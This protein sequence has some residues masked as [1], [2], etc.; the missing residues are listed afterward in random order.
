MIEM[1]KRVREEQKIKARKREAFRVVQNMRDPKV[2]EEAHAMMEQ[3]S[4]I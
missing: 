3:A 4:L 2:R 1:I